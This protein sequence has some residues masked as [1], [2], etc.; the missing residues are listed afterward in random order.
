MSDATQQN[1]EQQ[2]QADPVFTL[3]MAAMREMQEPRDGI[4]PTPVSYIVICFFFLLFGGWYLG[5]YS[6]EWTANG[7]SERPIAG[8]PPTPPPQD[9]MVLGKEVFGAC[10][11][12]HQDSGLGVAGTYP[13][14]AGSEFVLGDKRRLV[15]ILLKGLNGELI[16]N[17]KM[18]NS[19]MP[20]WEIREDEEIA[21][22]LTYVR[23]SWGNKADPVPIDLVT[24]V[25]KELA[26]KPEWRAAAL[27]EFAATPAPAPTA[28][29]PAPAK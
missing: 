12:C 2:P 7:L 9:P 22:V 4:A 20:A 11:Q 26:G 8:I 1:P 15:A 23:N 13:P 28:A 17:G 25:R 16:V 24:S 21:A 10:L 27:N 3:H 6:G 14:L 19:Q 5:Y 29:P 18:Y